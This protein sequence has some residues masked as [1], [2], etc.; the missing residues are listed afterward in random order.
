MSEY[1]INEQEDDELQS[2]GG[3]SLRAIL[4]LTWALRY[5]IIL[6]I[7]VCLCCAAV[8][9]YVKPK[10]YHSSA[11]VMVTTDKNAGMGSS[12]QMSFIA[13]M[14][15]MQSYNSLSN[16]KVIIKSTPVVQSVVE[17]LGLNVRYF[18]RNHM[19]NRETLP[20]E[21]RMTYIPKEGVNQND[22]PVYRIDYNVI[23]TVSLRISLKR[24][25]SEQEPIYLDKVVR[26]GEELE[27]PG[28]GTFTF[29][30]WDVAR[31]RFKDGSYDYFTSGAHYIMLYSPQARA[32]ELAGQI[33]VE[34]ME[35]QST[36]M[37]T[38]SILQLMMRDI[39]P[40]RSEAVLAKVIEKYNEL[41][42]EYY[43][44]SNAK[45][46]EFIDTR[47]EEL[48]GQLSQ[49]EGNIRDFSTS[50]HMVDL[51]SQAQL[52][53]S[54]DVSAQQQLQEV[55][56]QLALLQMISDEL[57]KNA[58][59][60]V[61][62]S[63]VGLNDPTI[64]SF[65]TSYNEACIERKRLLAGSSDSNP[66]VQRIAKQADELSSV[67]R[68]TI[69]NQ[70]TSLNLKRQELSR[71]RGR[72][73]GYLSS[74]PGQKISLAQIQR[75]QSV[76]EPLYVL[77]QKKREETMLT[78]VAEPDIARVVEYPDNNSVLVGPN[79]RQ[80]LIVA[81]GLGF[82]LPLVIIYLLSLMKTK[83][84]SPDDIASR[85]RVPILG[86]VPRREGPAFR[87][88]DMA[89][90]GSDGTS[91]VLS[92]AMRTI[93]T[94]IGFL[95][96]QVLQITS[97]IPGEG[98]S[99]VS[100]NVA[101][102]LSSIGKRVILVETDLRKG[103]QRKTFDLPRNHKDGL[104]NYLSGDVAD[105]RT[106]VYS[107]PEFANLDIMLKGAVPPNPNELLSSQRFGQLIEELKQQYDY[108]ILD[109]PPYLVIADPMTINK[110]VDRNIYVVRAGKA[111][112]RFVNEIDAAAKG[113]KLSNLS[114]ILNDVEMNGSHV[115]YGYSYHYGYGYG[116]GYRYGYG[117]GYN[118]NSET[119]R[120]GSLRQ[121]LR[122]IFGKK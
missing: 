36:R 119:S 2:G 56:V 13:D 69:D 49:V 39:H 19:V 59:Y 54:T 68:K 72:S 113:D 82:L 10:T 45:T 84:Q 15:G 86:V 71:Q 28:W 94:N 41:T 7:F 110:H 73:K 50:N 108:I 87:A 67:I 52:S 106:S 89:T 95:S 38:S 40:E 5:W 90:E 101:I 18:V 116:Y 70:Q 43:M 118:S 114:I 102:S 81:F 42:K 57:K 63:N 48:G 33:G 121:K 66:V 60:T 78:I 44:A 96:G 8:Y 92:E 75:E 4:E 30:F 74:V 32:R 61:L 46:M 24:Q 109:S 26:F 79:A 103:R 122:R 51:E 76:I 14:T 34:V 105:W 47:L 53:L 11:L 1:I 21:V 58:P 6:S 97:S 25:R 115:K 104:S 93:R 62:P 31:T 23:D 17:E 111:D 9:L 37:S 12:A 100:A 22:M 117:Y 65:I 91:S 16:E 77:L 85:T 83:V 20:Q 88:A 98:K 112:L 35:D 29:D 99:F 80:V 107:V 120:S 55:D 3:L 27:L 64:V